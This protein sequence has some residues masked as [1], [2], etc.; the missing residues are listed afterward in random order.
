MN[1]VY[2]TTLKALTDQ[3]SANHAEHFQGPL[4]TTWSPKQTGQESKAPNPCIKRS[5]RNVAT[6]QTALYQA[7]AIENKLPLLHQLLLIVEQLVP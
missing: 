3:K 7:Q 5:L 6:V 1:S 2:D 4:Q